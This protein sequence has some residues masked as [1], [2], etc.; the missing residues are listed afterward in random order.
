MPLLA[1]LALAG[2]C[3]ALSVR[4]FDPLVPAIA[5]EFSADAA[6]V[7]LLA[8]AFAFPYALSQP[9]L[10]PLGDALGKARII[11]FCLAALALALL[12]CTLAPTLE[13]L[14][15]ARIVC[16]LASGGIIPLSFAIM[17]D[18]FA[19]SERQVP[20][21]R[22]LAALLGGGIAGGIVSGVVG[23]Y[24]GWRAVGLIV[25]L[26]TAIVAVTTFSFLKPRAGAIRTP[27]TFGN[28]RT[29]YA[30]VFANPMSIVCYVAVFVE[31]VAIFGLL[32]Y[33]AV[34]L[35]QRG[36]GSLKEAGFVI[37]GFGLGGILFTL[38]V[39]GMLRYLGFANMIR[40][41]GVVC[42]LALIG[43]AF[44]VAWTAEAAAFAVVGLGFYMVH[45]S[46]QT[47]ATELAPDARGAAVALHAFF[48]FLGHAVGPVLFGIGL[49]TIGATASILISALVMALLGFWIASALGGVAP[50]RQAL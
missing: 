50:P 28:V 16:G 12:A 1:I 45:N 35:E 34:I 40:A 43:V 10:G 26:V 14:F 8:T 30:R 21:S 7:A 9:V 42:G 27:L 15:A 31:G 22:V 17:G 23:E 39:P 49:M 46:L 47:Q 18:R 19:Y 38:L 2:F 37:G 24:A 44:S 29:G 32:P 5:R 3:S 48:F 41:G 13:V 20:L 4:L 11:N 33:L 25:A 6:T 36:A